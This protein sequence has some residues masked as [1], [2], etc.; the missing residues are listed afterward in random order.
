MV[1]SNLCFSLLLLAMIARPFIARSSLRP[2]TM[3][4]LIPTVVFKDGRTTTAAA[5][6]DGDVVVKVVETG[7]GDLS[8][9]VRTRRAA[10]SEG[11]RASRQQ[12]ARK[13]MQESAMEQTSNV[14]SYHYYYAPLS[15]STCI[16]A[17]TSTSTTRSTPGPHE[18]GLR[19]WLLF[20][21]QPNLLRDIYHPR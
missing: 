8:A 18:R 5:R 4:L 21:P 15:H 11:R 13:K 14:D 17:T 10:S 7:V 12:T 1:A 6:S 20:F 2:T 9:A 19:N 3:H 16:L